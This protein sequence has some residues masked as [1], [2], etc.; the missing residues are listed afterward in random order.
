MMVASE[1]VG[2]DVCDVCAEEG[3]IGIQLPSGGKCWAHADDP[4]FETALKRLGEGGDIDARGVPITPELLHRILAASS[5]P[6]G[7]PKLRSAR[8]EQATCSGEV[9]FDGVTFE[10]AAR[11]DGATF[12]DDVHFFGATFEDAAIFEQATFLVGGFSE[13]TFKGWTTFS[14]ATFQLCTFDAAR[15]QQTVEFGGATFEGVAAFQFVTFEGKAMFERATFENWGLFGYATFAD[16]A[17][18]DDAVFESRVEFGYVTFAGEAQFRMA[19]FKGRASF[20]GATF[21]RDASFSK[22]IFEREARFREATFETARDFGPVWVR[23]QLD[24][25]RVT[26]KQRVQIQAAAATLCARRA[27]FPN[28]VHFRLLWAQVVLDDADLAAPS[29]L[30]GVPPSAAID[31]IPND[32]RTEQ[33]PESVTAAFG[34]VEQQA[35]SELREQEEQFSRSLDR[36]TRTWRRLP[37]RRGRDGR[38]RVLSLRRADVAGLTIANADLRACRF[39]GAHNLDRLRVEQS[40][41]GYASTG[42]RWTTRRMIAEEHQWRANRVR[43]DG[44]S[45]WDSAYRQPPAWLEVEPLTAKQIAA[46][47]RGLRKGLEDNKDEPGAAAFYYGEMEMRRHHT[48]EDARIEWRDCH[49]GHWAAAT[50]EHAVLWLY[51]LVSGYGL[52]AWRA[53][54]TFLVL[55]VVAAGLFAFGGGFASTTSTAGTPPTATTLPTS[56][57]SPSPTTTATVDTS[58]G[59]ALV[60]SAR[61]VIGLTRDPQPRLTRFGDVVQILLRIIGPVLLALAV[62]SIR[63][64]VKR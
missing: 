18:F 8:F 52:R 42:W 35:L 4:D 11:F 23:R 1:D 55:L 15:F 25:D 49:F 63:G 48:R 31:Q 29:I 38:P 53:L 59:G 5:G 50:T 24:L 3:G 39:A 10:G 37:P 28:G 51:W 32:P 22:A 40:I 41:F 14:G 7:R 16:L 44:R 54:A 58:F 30:T 64:R 43:S 12:E 56:T 6:E 27:R 33:P 26:F 19:T 9:G 2:W 21:E 20:T 36:F 61:T 13:A 62:L 17:R 57:S 47:Y 60:S 46:L 34:E 45:R